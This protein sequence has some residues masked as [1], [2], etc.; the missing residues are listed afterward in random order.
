MAAQGDIRAVRLPKRDTLVSVCH[1]CSGDGSALRSALKKEFK[2]RGC[3]KTVR[4]VK[5]SCLDICPKRAVAVAVAHDRA[6]GN[7]VR[8]FSVANG[9]DPEL[10]A[11]TL[12]P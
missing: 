7:G 4:V 11:S 1:T 10:V 2:R 9:A 3:G 8:Y 12:R 5:S 6:L